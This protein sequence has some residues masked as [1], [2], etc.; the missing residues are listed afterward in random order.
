LSR[1]VDSAAAH[2]AELVRELRA[3]AD[4]VLPPRIAAV[5]N[6]T[7]QPLLQ[8]ITDM[9]SPRL[10]FG[11]VALLGDAG[12]VVRPYGAELEGRP[13]ERDPRRIIRDYGAPN[14]LHD[15]DPRRFPS[16]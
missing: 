15:V 12:F 9:E 6:K 4:E 10:T 1:R 16:A 3:R 14:M 13:T 11:R 2:P 8:A 5:V 7:E